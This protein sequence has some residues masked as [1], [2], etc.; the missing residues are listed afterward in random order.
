MGRSKYGG[1][2]RGPGELSPSLEVGKVGI[3]ISDSCP[4]SIPTLVMKEEGL[5]LDGYC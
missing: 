4:A 5:K 3:L 1:E 2:K